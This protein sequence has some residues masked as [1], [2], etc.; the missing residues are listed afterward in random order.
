M[1]GIASP[2]IDVCRMD[3]D[4]GCCQGCFRTLDEIAGWGRAPAAQRLAI[5]AAVER[6]RADFDPA[7]SAQG[8]ELRGEC[9]R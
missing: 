2:C 7:G 1:N 5:L 4:S 3:S 6:R 8:G 9:E